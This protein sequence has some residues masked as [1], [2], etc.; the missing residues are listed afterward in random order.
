MVGVGSLTRRP[1][2][3]RERALLKTAL[4]RVVM[5]VVSV[6]VAWLVVGDVSDAL[7]I[8]LATNV[9]KTATYYCYER[10]WDHVSWGVATD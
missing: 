9:V 2:Q 8:G 1:L 6:A 4:Y 10:A 5:V 7:S 3:A